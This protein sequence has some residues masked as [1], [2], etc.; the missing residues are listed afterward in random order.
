MKV[1]GDPRV[2]KDVIEKGLGPRQIS[3]SDKIGIV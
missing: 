3:A 2:L 1:G